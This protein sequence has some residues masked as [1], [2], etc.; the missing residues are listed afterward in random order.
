MYTFK[1]SSPK[2]WSLGSLLLFQ[3]LFPIWG[4]LCFLKT[5]FLSC[6][7]IQGAIR[8]AFVN[9]LTRPSWKVGRT[10]F[11]AVFPVYTR[12]PPR[13]LAFLA[14]GIGVPLL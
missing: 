12:P 13:C 7:C 11:S 3:Q 6:E 1:S 10:A 9:N 8:K 4:F 2:N 14:P 5:H